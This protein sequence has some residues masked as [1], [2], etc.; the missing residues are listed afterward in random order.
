MRLSLTFGLFCC[1]PGLVSTQ[2]APPGQEH[3]AY[4]L[5]YV[6]DNQK[7]RVF[8]LTDI[9]NEPDDQQS[10]VR[11]MLYTNEFNTRGICATTSTHLRNDTHPER[12][13]HIVEAYGKVV[14]NLNK[15]VHPWNQYASGEDML[16]LITTG[17]SVY[18]RLALSEPLSE[19]AKH[20][21]S[22]LQESTEPLW[23]LIWGGPNTLAQALQHMDRTLS[24]SEFAALRARLRIYA[25]SDQDDTA[26]WIRYNW[27]DIFYIVSIHGFTNYAVA[28]WRGMWE[29]I[30][31]LSL[32]KVAHEWLAKYIEIGPLGATYPRREIGVEGDTPS[33]LYLVQNGL[34]DREDPMVG[35]WGGRWL[36]INVGSRVFGDSID[37]YYAPGGGNETSN[38]ATCARWRD[39]FQNDMA[40]RMQWTVSEDFWNA[41]HPPI[42]NVNGTSGPSPLRIS[43]VPGQQVNLDASAT[44]DPDQPANNSALSFEW[45]QYQQSGFQAGSNAREQFQVKLEATEEDGETPDLQEAN[46]AGFRP[47]TKGRMVKVTVPDL[48]EAEYEYHIILQVTN[49]KSP[50][51]P[52]RRYMRVK[53]TASSNNINP[54]ECCRDMVIPETKNVTW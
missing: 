40:A 21:I 48:P 29:G 9:L 19:G 14:D 42:P 52:V 32:H 17:P 33:F 49:R 39:H 54:D 36:P 23:V 44:Y 26:E 7:P 18:G 24:E 10:V 3:D 34:G 45:F 6:P 51:L 41:T 43:V 5:A 30:P 25:I 12:I 8:V 4:K 50:D 35:S 46:D 20:L 15:H 47:F 53:L 11:Y 16:S 27:P 31:S 38:K 1:L 28:T 37:T 2:D 13:E 22:R